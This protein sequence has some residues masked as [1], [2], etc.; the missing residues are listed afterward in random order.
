MARANQVVRYGCN[1]H[2]GHKAYSKPAQEL[3][4]ARFKDTPWAK[5]TPYWFDCLYEV[6]DAQYNKVA[7]C[8]TK[9]WPKQAPLK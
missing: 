4:Q 5:Q 6:W 9:E 1:W 7:N 8:N 3:L 2:G